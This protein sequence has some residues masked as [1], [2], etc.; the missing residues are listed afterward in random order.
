MTMESWRLAPPGRPED[1]SAKRPTKLTEALQMLIF[2]ELVQA[3]DEGTSV[4][5]SRERL[6]QKYGLT[7]EQIR[8]I[9][10]TGR[11]NTWAPL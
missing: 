1:A 11:A 8:M 6:M 2:L 3:Q 4:R 7:L 10:D 5:E 9:E